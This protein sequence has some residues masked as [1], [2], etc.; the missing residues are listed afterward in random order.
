MA[1]ALPRE[2]TP[3]RLPW[4]KEEGLEK[5]LSPETDIP[6]HPHRDH[7]Q[8]FFFPR[9]CQPVTMRVNLFFMQGQ[10][11][12]CRWETLFGKAT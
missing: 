8:P 1:R 12:T 10:T 3:G 11:A 2:G 9:I 5:T 4:K 7:A 6:N